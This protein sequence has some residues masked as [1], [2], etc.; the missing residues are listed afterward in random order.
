MKFLLTVVRANNR[1]DSYV[2]VA[3]DQDAALAQFNDVEARKAGSY[4]LRRFL[5]QWKNSDE[6]NGRNRRCMP[7]CSQ[8]SRF[9]YYHGLEGSEAR[10][11]AY[12]ALHGGSK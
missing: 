10:R 3:D 7:L 5:S 2:V 9:W 8:R 4:A 11:D 12:S 6:Q 1:V